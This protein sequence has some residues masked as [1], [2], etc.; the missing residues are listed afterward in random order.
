MARLSLRNH[1]LS[2]ALSVCWAAAATS[3][4]AADPLPPAGCVLWLRGDAGVE[5]RGAGEVVKWRDQSGHGRDIDQIVGSAPVSVIGVNQLPVVRFDGKGYARSTFD[6]GRGASGPCTI[7]LLARWTDGSPESC[8]LVLSSEPENWKFGYQDG[9]DQSWIGNEW[10]YQK[11]WNLYG[12]GSADTHWHLHTGAIAKEPT[13]RMQFWKDGLLLMDRPRGPGADATGPR[14]IALGG[15][16]L[17]KCEIAE[18]MLYDRLLA[19]E[20]LA[21]LWKYVSGKYRVSSPAEAIAG[22]PPAEMH[23]NAAF[24]IADGPFRP[25]WR[26]LMQYECPEWFRDAKFGIWAHWSPQ[27]EPEQGDWYAYHMYVQGS[28]I[29]DHHV[30][31]YGHPSAFGYKDICDAW[32]AKEWDPEALIRIYKRAGAKYFVALANHHDGFDC[33][34]SKYQPWN[35]VNV[36]PKRD[37]VGTWEALARKHGLRFGVSVHSAR[38]WSWFEVAHKSDAAGEFKGV[39]YDGALTRRD[40]QG[41]WWEGLDPVDL[42]GPHGADR[43]PAA[44]QAYARRWFARTKDLVDRY[45]PDLL[46]FDDTVPP[47]GDA[48]MSVVAHF[49]NANLGQNAGKMEAVY[50]TKIYDLQ[51]P[52]GVYKALVNDFEGGRAGGIQP[53]PW[54]TD[55]CIGNWHYYR[56]IRYRSAESVVEELVDVVSKNGNLLL[57]IPVRGDGSLDEAELSFLADLT[58]WMDVNGECIFGTRPWKV[59][60][61][62]PAADRGKRAQDAAAG[63]DA[64]PEVRF[65]TKGDALYAVALDWPKEDRLLIRAL[66]PGAGKVRSV[67]LLGH[68]GAL[69]WTQT[70]R[71][72]EVNLPAQKPCEYAFALKVIG[73]DLTPSDHGPRR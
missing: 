64:V 62:A 3:A 31:R 18:V 60:S 21:T 43:T 35:S 59:F 27:C 48:G 20:E 15:P 52:P 47:L 2:F 44:S 39:A 1:R 26:S 17:S 25:D 9:D 71:G 10:I 61:D 36:G 68:R 16:A 32:K 30:K 28:R 29:Y 72:L 8:K 53:Y 34:D 55:T 11:E 56:G 22:N 67:N 65:T 69:T 46:Y 49:L 42:Y 24:P 57:N 5:T 23:T 19:P 14:R 13:P 73:A 51:P 70:D 41:K 6:F 38:S 58:R 63:G 4:A 40:G 7:L 66:S 50:N 45:R 54:Q 12:G 33:W 37:I